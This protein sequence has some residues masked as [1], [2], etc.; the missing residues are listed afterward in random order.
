MLAIAPTLLAQAPQALLR[1]TIVAR[2][3]DSWFY[4]DG[5]M[6]QGAPEFELVFE[7]T[8]TSV[9]RRTIRNVS[10]GETL[11]DVTEY[12]FMMGVPSFRTARESLVFRKLSPAERRESPAVRAMGQPGSEAIEILYIGPDWMQSVKTVADY[13]VIERY[14]RIQ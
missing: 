7:V 12:F 3:T 4:A 5:R 14:A 10:T 13:M 11:S 6:K 9:I 1:R 8:D 2:G